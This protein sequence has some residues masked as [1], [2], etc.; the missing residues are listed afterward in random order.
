MNR[1]SNDEIYQFLDSIV[2]QKSCA[3]F[4]IVCTLFKKDYDQLPDRFLK[5]M[6]EHGIEI[7]LCDKDFKSHKKYLLAM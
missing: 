1:I 4:H 3:K 2:N 7:I 5:Y 6:V